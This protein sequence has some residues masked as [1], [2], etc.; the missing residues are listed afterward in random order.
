MPILDYAKSNDIKSEEMM[1]DICEEKFAPFHYRKRKE[2]EI[3]IVNMNIAIRYLGNFKN[4]IMTETIAKELIPE[5]IIHGKPAKFGEKIEKS[6]KFFA[7]KLI[8]MFKISDFIKFVREYSNAR[9]KITFEGGSLGYVAE[10]TLSKDKICNRHFWKMIAIEK[11][12]NYLPKKYIDVTHTIPM[13]EY[14]QNCDYILFVSSGKNAKP[15][16]HNCCDKE[17]LS[18]EYREICGNEFESINKITEITIPDS[19]EN[20]IMSGIGFSIKRNKKNKLFRKIE[21]KI[22]D[23]PVTLTHF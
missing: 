12:N 5:M 1:L 11:L 4:R 6:P 8:K 13:Y 16:Y 21:I 19:S 7:E 2:R 18:P 10:T 14:I 15:I 17:F 20:P 9:V 22:N 23:F 3:A